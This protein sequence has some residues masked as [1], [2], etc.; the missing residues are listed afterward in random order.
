MLC[1]NSILIFRILSQ[2]L[3][4]IAKHAGIVIDNPFSI[5]PCHT[6]CRCNVMTLSLSGRTVLVCDS[7]LPSGSS[8]RFRAVGSWQSGC[9]HIRRQ[10]ALHLAEGPVR[11]PPPRPRAGPAALPTTVCSGQ[12]AKATRLEVYC[13]DKPRL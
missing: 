1:F 5:P 12:D 7:G 11:F 9:Q 4:T 10:L 8:C 3:T 13:T 2:K 6:E